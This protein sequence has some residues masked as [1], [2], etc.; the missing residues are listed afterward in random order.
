MQ[1]NIQAGFTLIELMIAVAII[2]LL[3]MIAYPS[4]EDYI[5]RSHRTEGKAALN[6]CVAAEERYFT[7]NMKYAD[8]GE[9]PG[10]NGSCDMDTENDYYTI[11][12]EAGDLAADTSCD[13][14]SNVSNNCFIAT[15]TAKGGQLKDA[16]CKA[17]EMDSTG[18]K[19]SYSDVA[20]ST[21]TTA[22]GECWSR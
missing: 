18:A 5:L 20:K 14:S 1:Q 17:L 8:D 19:R 15:A 7:R 3:A 21:E 10:N 6:N 9:G 22:T 12:V 2:G 13:D 16:N 4:Y 11:S